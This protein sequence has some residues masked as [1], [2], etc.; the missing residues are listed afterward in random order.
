L[1]D[2]YRRAVRALTVGGVV[3]AS[4][5]ACAHRQSAYVWVDHV[6][7]TDV[8]PPPG[9]YRLGNADV[10]N[11]QVYGHPEMSGRTRVR[12]DGKLSIPLLGEVVAAGNAPTALARG[13]EE[14]LTKRNL[15]AAPT[16]VTIALEERAALR[17]AVLGEVSHPGLFTLD[18]NSGVA[19][20]L[21][22]AGGF[23]E[24]AHRDRV[25]VVRREPSMMR[26][27][28]R[29]ED[30]AGARGR[31]AALRLRPGDVVVVE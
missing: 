5:G 19:E 27:R 22:S 23:S 26:I 18:P 12:D 31:A 28:L 15:V 4:A 21:A 30:L 24:F 25:Y 9:E 6:A 11:V 3:V 20:A 17:V 8:T 29:Y 14:T 7:D 1:T 16:R 2:F 13:I 10:V